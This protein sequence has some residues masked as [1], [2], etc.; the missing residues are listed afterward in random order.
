MKNTDDAEPASDVVPADADD[1]PALESATGGMVGCA[2]FKEFAVSEA[3]VV[4]EAL[5]LDM[6]FS[7]RGCGFFFDLVS[8]LVAPDEALVA[9]A[10]DP[11]LAASERN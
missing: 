7:V 6:D 5:V 10:D 3:E 2:V 8:F 1:V 9:F 11:G 4:Y